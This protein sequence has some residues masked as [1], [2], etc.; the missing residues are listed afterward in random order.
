M[1]IRN[2]SVDKN[3]VKIR[4]GDLMKTSRPSFHQ[5]QLTVKAFAPDRKFCVCTTLMEYLA[6]TENIRG[7]H[8]ALFISYTK[9]H[10]PISRD[11]VARWTKVVL[12]RAGIDIGIFKPQSL[13]S[14][15]ICVARLDGA[16][17]TLLLNTMIR[18]LT[19]VEI[20]GMQSWG[21]RKFKAYFARLYLWLCK[22]V[23][24]V[25]R[26]AYFCKLMRASLLSLM[27]YSF[28][29]KVLPQQKNN[30][31]VAYMFCFLVF[32]VLSLARLIKRQ[33][34]R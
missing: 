26:V 4:F 16:K 9:P 2:I 32:N 12:K 13:R 34:M 29:L 31:Q 28:H 25:G 15:A 14:A 33:V 17:R 19:R 1:D 8:T 30:G 27:I 21:K 10:A 22:W 20:L 7:Q 6:R 5:C 24:W 18:V 3:S 11:S 23:R